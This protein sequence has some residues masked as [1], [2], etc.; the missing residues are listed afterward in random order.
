[1]TIF[2]RKQIKIIIITR[3]IFMVLSSWQREIARVHPVYAMNA[4]HRHT[5]ADLWTKP[6]DFSYRP[7]CR[8]L[9]NHY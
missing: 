1:M 3:T 5:A 9:D 7:A 6:T 4:E 8:L 2:N